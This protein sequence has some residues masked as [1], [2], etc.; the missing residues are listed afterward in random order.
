VPGSTTVDCAVVGGGLAGLA[1]AHGLVRAGRT[2]HLVEAEDAVGG[3]ARTEWHEGRPV[4]RGFQSL[5]LAYPETRRFLTA[6]GVPRRDLRPFARGAMIHDGERWLRFRAS[7]AAILRFPGLSMGDAAR[8]GR[9]AAEVAA[10]P[11]DALLAERHEAPSTEAYLRERGFGDAAIE[12]LFRPLFGVILLD[13]D[14]AADPGYF[15]FL[16]GMLVRGP[17]VLPSDGLGMVAEWAAASIRQAGGIVETGAPA[18]AL[19]ADGDR[20]VAVRLADGRLVEARHVVLATEAPAARPLLE[21][22]DPRSAARLP[23]E[24]ASVATAAFL[25]RRPLYRGRWILLNAAPEAGPGPRV[26]LICQTTNVV[27]PG[28]PEGPDVLLATSVTTG[29]GA[30]ASALPA[31]VEE[32]VARWSPAYPWDAAEHLATWEHPFAQFRLRAGVREELPG[33]RTAPRNLI[34]A[35]DLTRHP[36]IEGAVG[37]GVRAAGIVDALLP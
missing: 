37:S 25:L 5:F 24:A 32:L 8:L 26:D 7:P 34:L 15:R 3:R 17:A 18:A 20:I 9:L 2:V 16:L 19:E 12:T 11:P 13:R 29:R 36:S 1:C 21:P 6:I 4:D 23:L 31:A 33:P 28:A 35:G 27:R 22:H 10:R 30:D 14:L